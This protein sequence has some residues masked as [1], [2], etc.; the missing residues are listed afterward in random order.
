M[1]LALP[2]KVAQP[3]LPLTFRTPYA[4]ME[5]W[6][7]WTCFCFLAIWSSAAAPGYHPDRCKSE[8]ELVRSSAPPNADPALGHLQRQTPTEPEGSWCV[9]HAVHTQSSY[10]LTQ[11]KDRKVDK[12]LRLR[13]DSNSGS[14]A[15]DS[16]TL[17]NKLTNDNK[18]R[19]V[20]TTTQNSKRTS[21]HAFKYSL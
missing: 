15:H 13:L 12:M 8:R 2:F 9:C 1:V 4:P 6:T 14:T 5:W 21:K 3:S 17:S 16:M 18:N 7:R 11:S 19:Y 10:D 20:L